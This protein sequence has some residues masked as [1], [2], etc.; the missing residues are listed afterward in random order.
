MLVNLLA[1]HLT[2]FRVTW[3]RSGIL[4]IHS[5]LILLFVGEF[6]TR[7]YAV[8]Q[9]MAINEGDSVNYTQ[10]TRNYELA[11][12]RKTP[13][14][15]RVTVIPQEKLQGGGRITHEDL[16]VDLVVVRFMKNA[17]FFDP[18][19]GMPNIA[20]A[21]AGLKII[22]E[23][24]K[25]E[26]GVETQQKGDIPAVYLELFKKGT[27]DSL[28]I[29]LVTPLL[30]IQGVTE[31]LP[32]T[33][34]DGVIKMSMR[35]KRYYKPFSVHLIEFRFD[36]YVGTMT[37]KNYSSRVVLLD[38]EE[39]VERE[40]EISMNSPLRYRGETF[41]QADFD[42]RTEKTTYL[43]VVRNPGWIIPYVSCAVVTLGMIVHFGI[44]LTQFLI[45]R[46]AA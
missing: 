33:E 29:F 41:Y 23:E 28:G 25:E 13:D 1:A 36:K 31:P 42:K 18:T 24:M 32:G 21:G 44:F 39:G 7:E 38:P 34:G 16:P 11:F 10:D 35:N 9:Q 43:Q 22:A 8:E 27:Q 5:G 12:T 4:L 14:G 30:T 19:P 45:R 37:P 40:V 17:N 6:V 46:A 15:E 3:K 26:A 2:R 20:T